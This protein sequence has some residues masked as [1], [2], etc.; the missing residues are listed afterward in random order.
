MFER[1]P[2]R[3]AWMH[4]YDFRIRDGLEHCRECGATQYLGLARIKPHGTWTMDNHTILCREHASDKFE[5]YQPDP[6]QMM[7]AEWRHHIK[8]LYR[9]EES[10]PIEQR[11]GFKALDQARRAFERQS[12]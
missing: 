4:A 10:A 7:I 11:W 5:D 12:V 2:K 9:E 6:D 3:R 1:P 8:S